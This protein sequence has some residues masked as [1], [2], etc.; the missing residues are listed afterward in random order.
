[1]YWRVAKKCL[2]VMLE[3]SRLRSSSVSFLNWLHLTSCYSHRKEARQRGRVL[4]LILSSSPD[5]GAPV[6]FSQ[7]KNC[8]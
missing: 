7:Y 3:S 2:M 4:I 5:F 1:M 8:L 6:P